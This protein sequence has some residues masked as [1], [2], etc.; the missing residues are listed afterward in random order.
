MQTLRVIGSLL[1]L[2]GMLAVPQLL[3]VLVYF[4]LR[5]HHDLFAH[6][7]GILLPPILFFYLS[8]VMLSSSAREMQSQGVR[9]CGTAF[10]MMAIAMLTVTGTQ[11][12]LSLLAQLMLHGR[13]RTT[14]IAHQ[15]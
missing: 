15:I 8:Y 14:K 5:K 1:S 13:H 2:L 9:V 10:G 3:G 4:R 6:V 7:I 11:L 12:F